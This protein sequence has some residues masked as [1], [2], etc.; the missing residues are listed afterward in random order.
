M[1]IVNER[2]ESMC[3]GFGALNGNKCD[4]EC[5]WMFFTWETTMDQREKFRGEKIKGSFCFFCWS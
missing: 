5:V 2:C 4:A 3:I 1:R